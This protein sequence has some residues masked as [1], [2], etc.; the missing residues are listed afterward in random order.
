MDFDSDSFTTVAQHV[1]DWVPLEL[2]AAETEIVIPPRAIAWF[3]DV[4]GYE[5]QS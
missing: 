1:S 3:R 2:I 5:V 4:A